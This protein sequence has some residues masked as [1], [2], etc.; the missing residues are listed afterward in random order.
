MWTLE[1]A[2]YRS[3]AH[4]KEFGDAAPRI[5]FPISLV[6]HADGL[7]LFDAGLDPDH[8][9]DPAGAYGEMADRIDI[10]FDERHLIETHLEALG[11]SVADV[12]TVVA[13]HLHFDHAGALKRF[14]HARVV[15]GSGEWEYAHAPERF[16][17]SWYRV[18]DFGPQTGLTFD[19]VSGDT[20]L[21]AGGAVRVLH[22][23]GHT[24]GSLAL[25]VRLPERTL[26]LSG[27]VVHARGAY[28]AEIHYHGDEDSRAARASLRRLR[29]ILEEEAADLWIAHDPEDWE[30]FG[31]A[32]EKR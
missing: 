2:T 25:Q 18:E 14:P 9:G 5:P 7:V 26:V 21:V 23:P 1:P 4:A 30:R 16:A 15:L 19:I 6:E 11:F 31:G 27:D 29:T 28:D 32:G 22:L 24:P 20:D 12:T 13:S 3:P 17:S 10:R 8:V